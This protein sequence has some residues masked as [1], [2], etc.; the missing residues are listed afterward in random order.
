MRLERE[1]RGEVKESSA[2]TSTQSR[3]SLQPLKDPSPRST[4][5]TDIP[6]ELVSPTEKGIPSLWVRL[7]GSE[8]RIEPWG[9]RRNRAPGSVGTSSPLA[10]RGRVKLAR[11]S[12]VGPTRE[13]GSDEWSAEER[14]GPR[15]RPNLRAR[16]GSA[17]LWRRRKAESSDL[18]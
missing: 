17:S 3:V 1:G 13:P 14:E 5:L 8:T 2:R 11:T 6:P 4:T 18:G 15:M 10:A 12:R 7:Q 9:A 16:G